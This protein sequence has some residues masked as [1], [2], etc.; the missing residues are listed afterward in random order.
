MEGSR[1]SGYADSTSEPV[2]CRLAVGRYVDSS[3][4][5]RLDRLQIGDDF[6]AG[7]DDPRFKAH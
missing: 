3:S 7:A 1:V 6:G 4:T 2:N 5:L